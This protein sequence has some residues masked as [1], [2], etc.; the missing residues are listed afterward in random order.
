M[1][2]EDEQIVVDPNFREN[3]SILPHLETWEK[4]MKIPVFESVVH[5]SEDVYQRVKCELKTET[6]SHFA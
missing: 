4:M 2:G 5:Q 3:S 1:N 6:C